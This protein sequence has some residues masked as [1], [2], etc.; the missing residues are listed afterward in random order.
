MKYRVLILPLIFL[1]LI[2]GCRSKETTKAAE[3]SVKKKAAGAETGKPEEVYLLLQSELKLAKEKKVYLV[4]DIPNREILLKLGG[5]TVWNDPIK[6][7]PAGDSDS[8]KDFARKFTD[9]NKV[10]IRPVIDKHLYAASDKSSDSVLKIVSEVVRA[11]IDLMQRVI[12]ERFEIL[13]ANDLL[14]DIRTDVPGK[15]PSKFK[16]TVVELQHALQRPFG[17]S[18][19]VIRMNADQAITLYRVA[20][21][22]LPTLI[23]P[24]N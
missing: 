10:F 18:H 11:K 22:G 8:L 4:I 2:G 19:V 5:V 1:L 9:G 21:R 20:E 17:E 6:I 3:P 7:D 24:G 16:N 13:W 14:L 15:P 23:Y 12:P